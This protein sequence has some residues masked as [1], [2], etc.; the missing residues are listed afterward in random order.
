MG[1]LCFFDGPAI[2]F[3]T[4]GF[5]PPGYPGFTFIG[6]DIFI[7]ILGIWYPSRRRGRCDWNHE[8]HV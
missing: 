2:L 3:R 8:I 6:N 1:K 5:V 7:S 4:R